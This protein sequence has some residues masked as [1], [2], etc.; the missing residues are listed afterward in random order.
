MI[1]AVIFDLD[2][3]LVRTSESKFEAVK[4]CGKKFYNLS[5]S[6]ETIKAHW[7][8]PLPIFFRDVFGNVDH[9]DNIV[10]NYYAI[11]DQFP[12]ALY[13]DTVSSI[14]KLSKK[15]H[16]GILTSATRHI[17]IA[18]LKSVSFPLNYLMHIQTCEDTDIH[19]PDPKVFDPILKILAEKN[20][21]VEETMYVGDSIQDFY[22]A[23]GRGLH[24]IGIAD[25][26]T[27]K[28]VFYD[29]GAVTIQGLKELEKEIEKISH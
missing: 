8:K 17:V 3:T 5:I 24:F 14:S 29:K 26:L 7:G 18:D 23:R 20:I 12:T 28:K 9:E 27:P 21:T 1:K 11:R 16:L 25:R 13:E 15:Y 22:A 19:K 2:D 6:T 4:Y 10:L